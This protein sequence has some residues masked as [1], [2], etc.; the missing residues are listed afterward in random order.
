MNIPEVQA[1]LEQELTWRR[2]EIRFLGN[3][4]HSLLEETERQVFR[5]ALLVMLYAH[6]EGFCKAALTTFARAV[7]QEGLECG[8]LNE[9]LSASVLHDAFSG[10][11][12][13]KKSPWF[14][15]ALPNDE[16]L[17]RIA[18]QIEFLVE[19][20][21]ILASKPATISEDVIDPESNLKPIVLKKNLF[22]LGLKHDA[23]EAHDGTI[24]QLLRRRNDVAHGIRVAGL[25]ADEFEP[26]QT[27]VYHVMD[28]LKRYV[29]DALT[30]GSYLRS[31]DSMRAEAPVSDEAAH[32]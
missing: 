26:L 30:S 27:A 19:L 2:N 18:R 13:N 29:L 17:H 23:F 9:S 1:Q 11:S 28:E 10:L 24:D 22:R 3:V 12:G 5:K 16:P 7:N 25:R 6:F 4:M 14:K 15:R 31:V 8:A 20:P 32:P 21:G